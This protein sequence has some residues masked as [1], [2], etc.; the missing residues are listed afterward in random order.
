MSIK[1]NSPDWLKRLYLPAGDYEA[2]AAAAS[3]GATGDFAIAI[4]VDDPLWD[5]PFAHNTA[6]W[7]AMGY[8]GEGVKVG[9]IDDGFGNYEDMEGVEVPA[10]AGENCAADQPSDCLTAVRADS[11]LGIHGTGVAEAIYDVA[12]DAEL[13]LANADSR[14]GVSAAVDYMI[15]QGVDVVNMSLSFSWDGRRTARLRIRT[16]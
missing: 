10:P 6:A 16:A 5:A 3:A 12:P 13:Y 8:T 2:E 11:W 9:V 14:G 1:A 4:S 15:A 7:N